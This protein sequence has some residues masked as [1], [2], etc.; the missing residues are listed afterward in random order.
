MRIAGECP[1]FAVQCAASCVGLALSAAMLIA[2]RDPAVYLPVMT[3]II[4]YWLPAP[5]K[6]ARQ[7]PA[8]SV[9][10]VATHAGPPHEGPPGAGLVEMT[11]DRRDG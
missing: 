4:G 8:E 3:S 5:R 10:S 2:G 1:V 6:P 7:D 11:D 9:A